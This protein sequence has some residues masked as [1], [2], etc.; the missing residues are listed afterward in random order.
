MK[1]KFEF[2]E[3][4]MIKFEMTR[5]LNDSWGDEFWDDEDYGAIVPRG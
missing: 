3:I 1:K 5:V 4:E 2:P